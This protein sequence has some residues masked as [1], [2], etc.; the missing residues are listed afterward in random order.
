MANRLGN[1]D[2][3]CKIFVCEIFCAWSRIMKSLV[4][5]RKDLE[6]GSVA[7]VHK[8]SDIYLLILEAFRRSRLVQP[9]SGVF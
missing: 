2:S 9:R 4:F 3:K 7:A 6:F 1:E 8:I 5:I